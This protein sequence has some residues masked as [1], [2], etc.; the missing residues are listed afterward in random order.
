MSGLVLV[1]SFE[2]NWPVGER[3]C[4]GADMMVWGKG[5]GEG[6]EGWSERT[7]QE[8][9]SDRFCAWELNGRRGRRRR[10]ATREAK[11]GRLDCIVI[12]LER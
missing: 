12:N 5:D 9:R 2:G 4:G 7:A 11:D 3:V 6:R 1:S 10:K 8:G